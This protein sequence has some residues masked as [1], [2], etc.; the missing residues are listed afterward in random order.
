MCERQNNYHCRQ[1][2]GTFRHKWINVYKRESKQYSQL[3]VVWGLK[4]TINNILLLPQKKFFPFTQFL[5]QIQKEKTAIQ[6]TTTCCWKLSVL[7]SSSKNQTPFK[8][9]INLSHHYLL[10]VV[11]KMRHYWSTIYSHWINITQWEGRGYFFHPLSRMP[12]NLLKCYYARTL[13]YRYDFCV[14]LFRKRWI[15]ICKVQSRDIY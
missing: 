15:L 3:G 6:S 8:T 1:D 12:W 4:K 14:C 9:A 11:T 5:N 10:I 7:L 2:D 13:H